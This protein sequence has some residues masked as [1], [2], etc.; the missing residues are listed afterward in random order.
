MNALN[1]ER[2][3]SSPLAG[4]ATAPDV[5][6][7]VNPGAGLS[8]RDAEILDF[9]GHWWRFSGAKE[10]SIKDKFGM[11][12]AHYHQVLSALLDNPAALAYDPIL[13]KRLR[14]LRQARHQARTATA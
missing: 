5:A 4:G 1:P 8:A 13:V 3:N 9:E 7:V 11:T 14:R 6:G 10:A 2:G 12:P